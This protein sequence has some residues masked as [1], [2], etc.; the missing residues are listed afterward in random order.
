MNTRGIIEQV[1]RDAKISKTKASKALEELERWV[2]A[3]LENN[4]AVEIGSYGT[5]TTVD[6]KLD[7]KTSRSVVPD[8]EIVFIPKPDTAPSKRKSRSKVR[9]RTPRRAVNA[10]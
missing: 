8:P 2:S 4:E 3:R 7:V 6:K 10:R 9:K 1:S 5:F